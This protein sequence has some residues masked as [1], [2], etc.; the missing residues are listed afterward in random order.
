MEK[1]HWMFPLQ[2]NHLYH[3]YLI[4]C[5][6]VDCKEANKL[7]KNKQKAYYV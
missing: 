7:K 6:D 1:H 3:L 4:L 2:A 5:N